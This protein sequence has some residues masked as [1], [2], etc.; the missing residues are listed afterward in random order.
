[1][2][3][4]VDVNDAGSYFKTNVAISKFRILGINQKQYAKCVETENFLEPEKRLKFL[5]IDKTSFA[6]DGQGYDLKA[7][8]GVLTSNQLF[9][10]TENRFVAVNSYQESPDYNSILADEHFAFYDNGSHSGKFKI[11]IGCKFKWVPCSQ[12]S[13]FQAIACNA[14][15]WPWGSFMI[16]ECEVKIE[17]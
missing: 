13:Y 4:Q 3:A 15:G 14:V 5:V 9:N 6:D 11:I 12:M 1:V 16:T 7:D 17:F 8:D 10:Y 2:N